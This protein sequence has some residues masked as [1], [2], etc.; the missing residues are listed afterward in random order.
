MDA[1]GHMNKP[2]EAAL[3]NTDDQARVSRLRAV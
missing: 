3:N 1:V 2:A